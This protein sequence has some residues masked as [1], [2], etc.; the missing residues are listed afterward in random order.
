[1]KICMHKHYVILLLVLLL[2]PTLLSAQDEI[3]RPFITNYD[4]HDYG[5][6]PINWWVTEDDRGVMYFA[7]GRGVLEYDG[8]NWRLIQPRDPKISLNGARSF[9]KDDQGKI[10]LGSQGDLGYLE[11]NAKGEM[12]FISLRSEL[13]EEDRIFQEVWEVDFWEGEMV[14]RT[15]DKLFKWDGEKMKVIRSENGLHVG[16]I[17]HD[18]YYIRIW[19]VGLCVMEADTFRLLP[20]GEKFAS[21]RIYS[22][23]P[24]DDKQVLIGTRT[25]GFY[26]YDG[27]DF[28]PF[29]TELDELIRGALYLPGLALSDGRF[30]INTF[31]RGLFIMDKQGKLLQKINKD[32][33]LQDNGVDYVYQDSRGILWM[34]LFNGI[35]SVDLN[36]KFTVFG[37][38]SGLESD[39]VFGL[40]RHNGTLYAGTNNGVYYLDKASNQ[41]KY[42]PETHGQVYNI[43]VIHDK[44]VFASGGMGLYEIDGIDLKAI[45]ENV[46]Y[47]FRAGTMHTSKIDPNRLYVSVQD[48][49]I[50]SFYF[51]E[52]KGTWTE[53]GISDKAGAPAFKADWLE[54]D[55]G[56]L[57]G[58]GAEKGTLNRL[59]PAIVNGRLD[60]D[61]S[62]VEHFDQ[63][64]GLPEELMYMARIDGEITFFP[65]RTVNKL[66]FDEDAGKFTSFLPVFHEFVDTTEVTR[67]YPMED[68]LGRTWYN[69]G[70]G[71]FTLSKNAEGTYQVSGDAFLGLT[72]TTIWRIFPEADIS[73]EK[74]IVWMTGPDG[75][76]R[77][78]GNLESPAISDFKVLIREVK[79]DGDSTLYAG[80]GSIPEQVDIPFSGNTVNLAYAAPFYLG[81]DDME[82]QTYLEGFDKD[83]SP[84]TKQTEREYINLP[85]GQYQFKVK[86]HNLYY[87]ESEE[88]LF[89]FT[90]LPPW[91]RTWWAYLLYVL[92]ALALVRGIV[93]NRTRNLRNREKELKVKVKE[94]TLEVEQRLEE[95]ATVNRVSQALTEQLETNDLVQLVGDQMKTLFKSNIAYLAL[96]DPKT[97]IINFP[98]QH[99]DNMPS[100]KLGEGLTSKIINSGEPLLINQDISH[101]YK[102]SGI[103][104]VGKTASSYL[105]VPIPVEGKVIGVL[106]VQSTEQESRFDESDKRLLNTIARHVGIALHNAELFEEAKEATINAEAANEAKSAFLSTVSHE[107]RTPLTSV[108]GFAKIIRK[109][110]GDR[111]FPAVENDDKRVQKAMRQVNDNLDVVV[112]EGERL[113][114]LI[115]DVLDLAKIESG[116]VEWN[117][118]PV[119]LQDIINRATAATTSLFDAKELKLKTNVPADLPL[120]HGDQDK[121]IQVMVNLLSNAVKFTDEG[122]VSIAAFRQ[123][124]ELKVSITDTGIGISAADQLKVF[125]K[126]KQAGDTLTD[127]PQGTGLGLPICKEIVEQ[128][129]G[130]IHLE[131]EVG[132]GSTFYFTIPIHSEGTF[133][134]PLQLEKVVA[135]LKKQIAS[136]TTPMNGKEHTILVVD[137]DTPIRS[138][139]RQEL[140]EIGYK[141]NE[142]ANGKA[143]L[144]L[145]RVHRPDL[146]LLDVMMPEMNGFDVAAVLKNDPDT[147]DI[148]IIILSIVEDKERGYNIGVDRYLTKPIDTKQLFH[149]V[150]SLLEQ[151]VSN[152]KVLVV[153]ENGSTVKTLTEVLQKRGYNVV[154]SDGKD[155]LEKATDLQPDIIML[156]ST[157]NGNREVVKT[158]KFEKGMENVLFLVYE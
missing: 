1:M 3:G 61:Q 27:T 38:Q 90:I 43:E 149:A 71:P 128:H 91:Y 86:A 34:A 127:K 93:L 145:I 112:S 108:L 83:W 99:G 107:L 8:K 148:P 33:G 9:A 117:F 35:S 26:L 105:G 92:G 22:M 39:I 111:I 4:Y 23:L 88:T 123:M 68:N 51:D 140:T 135:S 30:V 44:L 115:N 151:G 104:Q 136:V 96:L 56:R 57:W 137:D 69:A 122:T 74:S 125:D 157:Q 142:A 103:K 11:A 16:K 10:Y 106:S 95:L 76:I 129:G 19:D 45:R 132:K 124:D 46:N 113:T 138:L 152:K 54:D 114:K 121:L 70:K 120:V 47:D 118:E 58:I 154:E 143:A 98:Y 144:D 102:E 158:L 67:A 134:K 80:A 97:N 40:A 60:F 110:L 153:D 37:E 156:N 50:A 63:S 36:S 59:T 66:S 141:V 14:F 41:F 64:H 12:Q 17:V 48:H 65:D 6:G 133:V 31:S 85:P 5:A 77:Y 72:N 28:K 101:T 73:E 42:V 75:I 119:F 94:R 15:V 87:Q 2:L 24:Y 29:K 49:G 131:S 81:A 146:I 20:N 109:R 89:S 155:V 52:Q 130:A 82:Y 25:K 150:D 147:M 126:F 53:E 7:N 84:K 79:Y 21:E 18:K 32:N 62:E 78:E 55:E 139:L 116:K 13:P 100:M